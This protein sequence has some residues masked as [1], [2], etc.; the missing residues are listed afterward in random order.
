MDLVNLL[1]SMTLDET[2]CDQS[3]FRIFAANVVETP[4]DYVFGEFAD[5]YML[6]ITQ[7][8]K[9]GSLLKVVVDTV[10]EDTPVYSVNVIFGA[11]G[12]EQEA[13]ARLIA[14][15]INIQKPLMLFLSLKDYSRE[16]VKAVTETLLNPP[17]NAVQS[18]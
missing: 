12:E 14:E 1:Q 11:V 2:P 6:I 9:V 13:A 5:K 17:Q 15:K 3:N 7:F 16:S 18:S 8:G 4:T 10:N